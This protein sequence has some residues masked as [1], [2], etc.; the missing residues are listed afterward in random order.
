MGVEE[1]NVN[2]YLSLMA[3][4]G[5]LMVNFIGSNV[6]A[7]EVVSQTLNESDTQAL[8]EESKIS[9]SIE[10]IFEIPQIPINFE[11]VT[12]QPSEYIPYFENG[13]EIDLF[14]IKGKDEQG[15][16]IF[17][18]FSTSEEAA[19]YVVAISSK[20]DVESSR[21]TRRYD[22]CYSPYGWYFYRT[23]WKGW[24]HHYA[25]K[26]SAVPSRYNAYIAGVK[27]CSRWGWS[28]YGYNC[29]SWRVENVK[30]NAQDHVP[31]YPEHLM[32]QKRDVIN[33]C[34]GSGDNCVRRINVCPK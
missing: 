15:N 19:S 11:E 14:L 17:Y 6:W 21:Q 20:F 32:F 26:F 18:A 27:T 16:D 23:G 10:N 13:L 24:N 25:F 4:I 12:Y 8:I 34:W 33:Y 28:W 29:Q 22:G 7:E 1:R 9:I 30:V 2:R 3:F 31:N 5:I